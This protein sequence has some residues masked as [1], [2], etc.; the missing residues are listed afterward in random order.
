MQTTFIKLGAGFAMAAVIL[1][2]FGAHA[3]EKILNPDQL[4]TYEI[5]VRYQFYH[6]LGLI[7]IGLLQNHFPNRKL[8]NAGWLF[9]TGITFFSGSL[10]LLA[11][12]EALG[13]DLSWLGPIT[14][15]G[16]S[17]LIIGW[18]LILLGIP[19]DQKEK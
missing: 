8:S 7:L 9:V 14:P 16:G 6:A 17:L 2:A 1:G 19:G 12:Q 13:M 4:A 3:L 10:Y 5:G 18:F 15:I 11:L